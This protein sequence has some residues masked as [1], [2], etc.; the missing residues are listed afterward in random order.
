MEIFNLGR[1]TLT[2]TNSNEH[3]NTNFFPIQ[4]QFSQ[5]QVSRIEY[6]EDLLVELREKHNK[7][8]SFFRHDEFIYISN[9]SGN[10][11]GIGKT[12]TMSLEDERVTSSLIKHI[13]FKTFLENYPKS[14]LNGFYPFR[15][16]SG[17]NETDLMRTLLPD[18]LKGKLVYSPQIECQIRRCIIDDKLQYGFL[19]NLYRTYKFNVTLQDLEW[20]GFDILNKE[21]VHAQSVKGLNDILLPD[22]TFIGVLQSIKGSIGIVS[23]NE[24]EQEYPLSQLFLRKTHSNIKDYLSFALEDEGKAQMILDKLKVTRSQVQKPEKKISAIKYAAGILFTYQKRGISFENKDGFCFTVDMSQDNIYSS[25]DLTEATYVF[26]PAVTRTDSWNDRGLRNYGPYD[27]SYFDVKSPKVIAICHKKNR[28]S[29]SSFLGAFIGGLPES[30]YFKKGLKSKYELNSV[31]IEIKE[32]DD[33]NI[34]EVKNALSSLSYPPNLVLLEI[35]VSFKGE[36]AVKNS[37]YYQAKAHILSLQI[38]VQVVTAENIKNFDEYKLNAIALQCYAKI[39]GVPWSIVTSQSIDHEIVVGIGHSSFRNN[40]FKGNEQA[41]IVGISTFFSGDGQYL[42]SGDVKDVTYEEYFDVLL[43]SLR[44]SLTSLSKSYAW[45]DNSTVRLIF[46]I[47]KPLKNLEFEVVAELIKEFNQYQIQFAFV[48]IS[49]RHPHLMY[50]LKQL[51]MSNRYNNNV[52]GKYVPIRGKNIVLNDSSCLIQMLGAKE[53]KTD[54]HGASV[55]LLVKILKPSNFKVNDNLAEFLFHDLNYIA[56]QVYRF[57]SLSWRG[58]FPNQKPATM[59]YSGLISR[60]LG[61]L[62]RIEGWNSTVI[63]LHLKRKKWFL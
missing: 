55:P 43:V 22:E 9:K 40:S 5:Y 36:K 51:G 15:L 45:K 57:S 4:F 62:R 32:I 50:D 33:F 24:G 10:D 11:L 41:R 60:L 48:T 35:P 23:T 1:N 30:K 49:E 27:K 29:M 14:K 42:M 17:K 12:I 54:S 19:V 52:K 25:F 20:E 16:P 39:G 7:S 37:L 53:I 8:H 59:L 34:E 18:E 21:V 6:N 44:E 26:D 31:D 56:Q 28:G 3:M 58:F 61:N 63:N 13:F 47:F 38:P 2:S 46:H